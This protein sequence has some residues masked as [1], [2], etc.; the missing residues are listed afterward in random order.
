MSLF[1]CMGNLVKMQVLEFPVWLSRLR[2]QSRICD[3][4]GLTLGLAHRGSGF[5]IATSCGVGCRQGSDQVLLWLAVAV[6]QAGS[7]NSH[8]WIPAED[9]GE[10][11]GGHQAHSQVFGLSK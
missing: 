1:S 7:Y 3:D 6:V 10:G 11:R 2:T 9:G 5:G 4:A 8:L